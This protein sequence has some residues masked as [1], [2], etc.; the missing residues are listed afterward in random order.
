MQEEST[1]IA[2]LSIGYWNINGYKSKFLGSKIRDPEFLETIG[3]CDIIGLGEIQ[4]QG[5]IDIDGYVSKKPKIREK[6]TKGPKISGG[7]IGVFVKK[8]FKSPS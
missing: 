5:E 6:T 3:G 2:N 4:C 1:N 8:T 7:N